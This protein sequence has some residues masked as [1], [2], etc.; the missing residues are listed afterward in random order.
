MYRLFIGIY[1][2]T[3]FTVTLYLFFQVAVKII[4]KTQLNPTSLKKVRPQWL[5]TVLCCCFILLNCDKGLFR[6]LKHLKNV[7]ISLSKY[8][9]VTCSSRVFYFH[10]IAC[11]LRNIQG[12]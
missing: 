10:P 12:F 3:H 1:K 4:D 9:F 6:N 2:C 11:I 7:Y 5:E 8:M